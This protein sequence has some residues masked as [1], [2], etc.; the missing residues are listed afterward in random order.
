MRGFGAPR[1][2]PAFESEAIPVLANFG[3]AE[4]WVAAFELC[5][6]SLHEKLRGSKVCSR[7]PFKQGS[8][9]YQDAGHSAPDERVSA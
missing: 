5:S 9:R 8:R 7:K 4:G 1:R 3:V 6:A 2:E